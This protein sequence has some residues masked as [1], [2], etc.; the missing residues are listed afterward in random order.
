MS[1]GG[2]AGF[3]AAQ[4]QHL[5]AENFSVWGPLHGRPFIVPT[6][7]IAFVRYHWRASA[8]FAKEAMDGQGL[9]GSNFGV[10]VFLALGCFLW[11][12]CLP[13]ELLLLKT[14]VCCSPP[15]TH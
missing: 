10:G 7:A 5:L 11:V 3:S 12:W 4:L 2:A 1:Y 13:A 15:R 9:D 8:E 14:H 6:K